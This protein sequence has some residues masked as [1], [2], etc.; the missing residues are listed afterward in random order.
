MALL[1][2]P[3]T[4][5]SVIIGNGPSALILSY[6]LHGYIP[7]YNASNP[8]PDPILHGKLVRSPCLLDIDVPSLTEHFQASRLSYSTQALPINVLLDTL[9]RPLADTEPGAFRTCV[10]WRYEPERAVEHVVLG[11]T[12][13]AGGQWADN[14]VAASW[15]IGTLSYAEMLSLPGYSLPDHY[16][17]SGRAQPA[18]FYRPTR[19][20]IAT[21]L[22]V[23]PE[24]V[25]ISDSLSFRSEAKGI[26]RTE[27][28]FLIASHNL[29][30][31]HL[32]LASGIF[33]HLLPARPQLEPLLRLPD[34]STECTPPLLVVGSGFTAADIIISALPNRRIIHI[35]KW[36]PDDHP[37]P[38][39]ACHADAYPDYA[40]VYRRMKLS[41]MKYFGQDCIFSP[42]R[43]RKS[44][45]FFHSRDWDQSYEGLPNTYIKDISVRGDYASVTLQGADGRVF[46][47][48]I[49]NLEYVIGRRGSLEYLDI[50][51]QNEVLSAGLPTSDK[52]GTIS[53]QSLRFKVERDL[54]VAPNVFVIG[55]LTGDSLVRFAFGGCVFAAQKILLGR[56]TGTLSPESMRMSHSSDALDDQTNRYR[57]TNGHTDLGI[58]RKAR[59]ASKDIE[60]LKSDIWR[61]SGWWSGTCPAL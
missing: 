58:S 2:P 32:I 31:K 61:N 11:N 27:N 42:L 26:T 52:A 8:H 40:G 6:I 38:L 7:Y 33:S 5:D 41:A 37:S 23:Y 28:G 29:H 56:L 51:L 35:Y 4:V 55:S 13:N 22:A 16:R 1:P 15:D 36:N 44:N 49:A 46:E 24:A 17:A 48:E 30:C 59:S 43:K 25:G 12:A 60:L 18:E 3:T 21:Y 14:P 47:R 54:Q 53:G 34:H 9:I 57:L 19:R 50:N 10:E 39:R 20:E 45:P